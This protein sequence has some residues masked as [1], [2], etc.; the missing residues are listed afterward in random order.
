MLTFRVI[1]PDDYSV[2]DDGQTIGR[3]RHVKER[4]PGIWLWTITVRLLS[5]PFGDA[6]TLD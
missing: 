4:V 2:R 6:A 1:G 5:P 3:I